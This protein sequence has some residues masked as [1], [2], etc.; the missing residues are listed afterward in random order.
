MSSTP[1]SYSRLTQ[2]ALRL[3]AKQIRLARRGRRMSQHELAA[4]IGVA[5]STLQLI[6]KGSPSVAVGLVFE[7][8]T[9]VG[10]PLFDPEPVTLTRHLGRIDDKLA[11]M[12]KAIRKPRRPVHNDF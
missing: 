9:L 12:P 4:R 6:E 3:I 5:R 10:V 2:E 11:L 1:R 7:A 8:A